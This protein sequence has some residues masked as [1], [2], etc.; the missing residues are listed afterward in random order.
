MFLAASRLA[1]CKSTLTCTADERNPL[2]W[3]QDCATPACS[4]EH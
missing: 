4:E 1:E 2:T 3:L